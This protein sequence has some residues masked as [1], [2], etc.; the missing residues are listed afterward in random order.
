[1]TM[2]REAAE[3]SEYAHRDR[4]DGRAPLSFPCMIRLP[5]GN[6]PCELKDIS[7]GG[8]RIRTDCTLEPGR[9][10]WLEF[11]DYEVFATVRWARNGDYGLKFEDRLPK[12]IV[13]QVQGYSVDLDDYQA[14]QSKLAAKSWAMGEDVSPPKSPLIRL[15]D[16]VGPKSRDKFASCAKCD[17]G[18]PCASQC[19]YKQYRKHKG[20]Y[21]A[22]AIMYLGLAAI[23]GALLGIGSVWFD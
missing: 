9:T 14:A 20:A 13:M 18:E 23:L 15:L 2:S 6:F 11:D 3:I 12:V 19:G 22:R 21:R 4:K 5:D 8:A 7:L 16:V 17:N 10:L 1:M